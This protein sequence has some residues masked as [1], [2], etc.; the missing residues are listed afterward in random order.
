MKRIGFSL[1]QWMQFIIIAQF[2]EC[3]FEAHSH[4]WLYVFLSLWPLTEIAASCSRRAYH[5]LKAVLWHLL[6]HSLFQTW[7]CV[8][9]DLNYS[10]LVLITGDRVGSGEKPFIWT[11]ITIPQLSFWNVLTR[12]VNLIINI[13]Q[14]IISWKF[15]LVF[16]LKALTL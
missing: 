2:P 16:T 9:K 10:G 12:S 14:I 6:L 4:F 5:M 1:V 13:L 8:W 7:T 15:S 11:G 3:A